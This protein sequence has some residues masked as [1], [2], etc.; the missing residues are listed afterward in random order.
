MVNPGFPRAPGQSAVFPCALVCRMTIGRVQFA[1][2]R[3][4][5]LTKPLKPYATLWEEEWKWRRLEIGTA[6]SSRVSLSMHRV[7]FWLHLCLR[8][9]FLCAFFWRNL[10]YKIDATMGYPINVICF[11]FV[12]FIHFTHA[13]VSGH[14]C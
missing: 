4:C 9:H 2:A 1:V 12:K 6:K 8:S 13:C 3:A 7:Y 10:C 14:V 11:T 5:G